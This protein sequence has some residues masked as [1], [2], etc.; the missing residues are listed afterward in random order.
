[1]A[2]A[3]P[4][5]NYAK[6]AGAVSGI[7]ASKVATPGFLVPLGRDGKFPASVGQVADGAG[8]IQTIG[9]ERSGGAP[10]ELI[11]S[12][13]DSRGFRADLGFAVAILC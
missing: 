5:A 3:V 9:S 12:V 13:N 2:S 8:M 1:M 6:N 4:I 11:V 10:G 7:R